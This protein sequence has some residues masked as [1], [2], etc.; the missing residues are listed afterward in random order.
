[1]IGWFKAFW[2]GFIEEFYVKSSEGKEIGTDTLVR[3]LV[4]L[5]LFGG[6][7]LSVYYYEFFWVWFSEVW[8]I[9]RVPT[10]LRKIQ[11]HR[12][13]AAGMASIGVISATILYILALRNRIRARRAAAQAQLTELS[14]EP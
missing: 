6:F 14:E 8:F 3:W 11:W 1:M 9:D 2:K 4:A 5:V 12:M 10:P 7:Y 13:L